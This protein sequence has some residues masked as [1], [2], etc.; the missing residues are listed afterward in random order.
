MSYC[1]KCGRYIEKD[2]GGCTVCMGTDPTDGS[3]E[4]FPVLLKVIIIVMVIFTSGIGS[5]VGIVGGIVLM[6]HESI[7]FRQ[8][9]KTLLNVSVAM[10][11]VGALCCVLWVLLNIGIFSVGLH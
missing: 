11:V 9:G 3:Q 5:I 1:P 6:K 8:F 2:G 4:D 10:L 7:H